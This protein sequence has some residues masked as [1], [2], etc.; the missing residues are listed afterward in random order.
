M[1]TKEVEI[2]MKKIIGFRLD[3]EVSD[4]LKIYAIE[5]KTTVQKLLEDYVFK[6]LNQSDDTNK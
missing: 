5:N 1:S 3:E 6:I 2:F 4:K